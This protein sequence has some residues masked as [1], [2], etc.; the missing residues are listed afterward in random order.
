MLDSD[1]DG[2]MPRALG[3]GTLMVEDRSPEYGEAARALSLRH[4]MDRLFQDAFVP[5]GAGFAGGQ[6][7]PAVDIVN[8]EDAFVVVA[9]LPGVKPD[10][11]DITLEDQTLSIRGQIGDDT[12]TEGGEYLYRERKFG[13]FS[14]QIEFPT[15]VEGESAEASFEHGLLRLR[16]PKAADTKPRRIAIKPAERQAGSSG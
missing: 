5:S 16:V 1:G 15:R 2:F 10:Q 14:R 6:S 4:I 9:S 8:T 7:W 13:T 3:G 12:E 11:V